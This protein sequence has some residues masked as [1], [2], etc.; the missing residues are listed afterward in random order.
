MHLRHAKLDDLETLQYWDTKNHVKTALGK[1]DLFNWKKELAHDA[2]WKELLIAQ[3]DNRDIG[4]IQIIDPKL[5][6]THYWGEVESNLRAIDIWIGEEDDIGKGFGTKMMQ[7]AISK[8]FSNVDVIGVL[9]D[10]RVD[11]TRACRFYEKL[12]F[13]LVERRMFDK[14]DCYVYRLDRASW[15][16]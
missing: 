3:E 7:H 10:P 5:E 16:N 4:F 8:C 9:V 15:K 2:E 11:N 12:G 13:E 14:D 1:Y 6:E